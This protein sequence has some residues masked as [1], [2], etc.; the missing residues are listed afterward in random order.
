MIKYAICGKHKIGFVH[1]IFIR[2]GITMSIEEKKITKPKVQNIIL[3]NRE[4]IS[5]SGVLDV[6][7]FNT[8]SVNMDTELGNL[9]VR[10]DDLRI[11]KLNLENSEM[12]IE[13]DIVSCIYSDDGEGRNKGMG[14]F[15]K[16]FK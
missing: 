12:V 6:T 13:G 1:I 10:G 11:S 7:N 15:G 3:E 16:L 4:R 2:G 8:E 14:L 9:V 5:I